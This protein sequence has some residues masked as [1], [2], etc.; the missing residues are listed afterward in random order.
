MGLI[1][2]T[3]DDAVYCEPMENGGWKLYV[4]IAD[5]SYYVT[6]GSAI[7]KEANE[8]GTSVY[9]P[10]KVIPMLPEILSNDLC[11]LKPN[12][13]RLCMVC[14]MQISK[15]G[16]VTNYSC[17][18]AVMHSHARFTYT[19]V[20]GMLQA[21]L[22]QQHPLLKNLQDL[23]S[24][25][26]VLAAQRKKRGA[27]EFETTETRIVFDKNGKISHIKPI[28]R[29]VAH[30]MI[31]EAMLLAN[32]TVATI[33]EKSKITTL[34]R[35]HATPDQDRLVDLRDFLKAFGLRLS[36]GEQPTAMDYAHLLKRVSKRDDAHLIQTVLL[37]SLKQAIYFPSNDGHFGLAYEGY[38]H[39]TSPIRRYPDLLVHRALKYLE[40]KK[41]IKKFP[42]E[43]HEMQELGQH[44]SMTERRADR[45]VRDATDWLKCDYMLD[46][47]GQ[48]FEGII[49]DV[50]GF[51]VF[52]ELKRYLCTRSITYY[53]V[54]E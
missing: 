13:D 54:K 36:G 20:A 17:Y 15:Q 43:S 52:V 2:E 35:V 41:N 23:H 44:C 5:V 7:D 4:A 27:L 40:S 21:G 33:L 25:Y 38:T 24:L 53:L 19:K 32:I 9:F 45:A 22:N 37:R 12:E 3:F 50:T 34:Y 47:V 30:K 16:E 26:R 48:T 14:E 31:E 6:P 51:G 18:S 11:S 42:Y 39:F 8:R 10:S 1:P 28:T 29:N 46:K 49:V